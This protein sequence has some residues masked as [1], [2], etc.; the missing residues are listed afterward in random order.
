MAVPYVLSAIKSFFAAASPRADEARLTIVALLVEHQD[1]ELLASICRRHG[2]DVH[3]ASTC[4][5]ASDAANRLKAPLIFCDRDLPGT[6]WRDLVQ[7]LA[8]SPHGA[9]VVLV[10]RVVDAYLW[11][12]VGHKGGYDVLSKPLHEVD[13]VRVVKLGWSYWNSTAK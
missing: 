7:V 6:D 4:T 9:C 3:F 10:S 8:A 13:V 5:D 11:N 2:W 12:E 1:R